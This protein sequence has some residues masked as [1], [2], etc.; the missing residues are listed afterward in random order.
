MTVLLVPIQSGTLAMLHMSLQ[1]Y[2]GNRAYSP[3]RNKYAGTSTLAYNKPLF[4]NK[5][6]DLFK[7]TKQWG[8]RCTGTYL[9]NVICSYMYPCPRK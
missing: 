9:N 5:N 7:E 2:A 4:N 6:T 3:L 1:L 8:L